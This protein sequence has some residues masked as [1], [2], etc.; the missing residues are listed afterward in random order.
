M[1]GRAQRRSH[2]SQEIAVHIVDDKLIV[3]VARI[4]EL[5][6]YWMF[7]KSF[8]VANMANWSKFVVYKKTV[9]TVKVVHCFLVFS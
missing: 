1:T 3:F 4:I 2:L 7:N 9:V 6:L 8:Y 5:V